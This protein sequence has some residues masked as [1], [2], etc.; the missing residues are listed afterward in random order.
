[1]SKTYYKSIYLDPKIN[2]ME[3]EIKNNSIQPSSEL[4]EFHYHEALDRTHLIASMI[5]EFLLSHPVYEKHNH[6][7][8]SAEN[9]QELI[10]NAYQ[11][12]GALEHLKQIPIKDD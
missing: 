9:A 11:S 5:E 8:E 12:I 6:L 7:R 1:M 4:D 2:S 3:N 10:A